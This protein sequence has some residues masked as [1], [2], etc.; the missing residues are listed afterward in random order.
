MKANE[1]VFKTL[2]KQQPFY[3][4]TD[5]VTQLL[6]YSVIHFGNPNAQLK[7]TVFTNP[8]CNPCA[9]MHKR[10]GKLL[11]DTKG[12]V[13]IQYILSAFTPDLEFANRYLIA[14]YL[15]KAQS[16]FEQII[17]DWFERGK[18]LK[19]AFFENLQLDLTHPEIET[20]FQKHEAWKEKTKLRATPT[21]LV[22]GYKLPDNYKIEDMQYFTESNVDIK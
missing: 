12:N 3:E 8:F 6:N 19:E 17:A 14:T 13:C 1:D 18:P 21:I 7:I 22:N 9:K 15:E 2:L 11:K 20:E 10:V 5:S 16:E 4:T